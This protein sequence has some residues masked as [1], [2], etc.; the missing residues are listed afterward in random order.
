[1]SLNESMEEHIKTHKHKIRVTKWNKFIEAHGG[2]MYYEY[3]L[4]LKVP[5][6]EGE[7]DLSPSN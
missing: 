4:T 6:L 3:D 5:C 1:M 2:G 7:G